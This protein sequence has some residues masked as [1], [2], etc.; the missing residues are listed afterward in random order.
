MDGIIRWWTTNN[1]KK[2]LA[3]AFAMAHARRGSGQV[4]ERVDP[5][6]DFL[7]A[8]N[9]LSHDRDLHAAASS[10]RLVRLR[11]VV[12]TLR[13]TSYKNLADP[14]FTSSRE[15]KKSVASRV[16]EGWN[17]GA[18]C[19]S[20]NVVVRSETRVSTSRVAEGPVKQA[21]W[22]YSSNILESEWILPGGQAES[23]GRG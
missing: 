11:I 18:C 23:F 12:A 13:C 10:Y 15:E 1:Q 16:E 20:R 4:I 5:L 2:N 19:V 6:R 21:S 9:D 7:V 8:K 17:V 3:I 14:D 22:F